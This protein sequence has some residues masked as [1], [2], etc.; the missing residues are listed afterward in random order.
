MSDFELGAPMFRAVITQRTECV[1]EKGAVIELKVR[2]HR[3][4]W[5]SE[6]RKEFDVIV[7]EQDGKYLEACNLEPGDEIFVDSDGEN[8]C[9]P[10]KHNKFIRKWK[11]W[12]A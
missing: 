3:K 5:L 11:C 2:Y 8:W 9:D 1:D 4:Y 7:R 6:K 10:T 12:F